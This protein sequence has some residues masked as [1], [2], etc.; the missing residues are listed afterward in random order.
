[1]S[2]TPS[3]CSRRLT[4]SLTAAVTSGPSALIEPLPWMSTRSPTSSGKPAL[5]TMMSW[6]LDSPLPIFDDSRFCWPTL[7][8]MTVHHEQDPA[9]DRR[10]AVAGAP[11]P[12]R[13]P[14]LGGCILGG[15][16]R[17]N[18]GG[19]GWGPPPHRPGALC[20]GGRGPPRGAARRLLLQIGPP[21]GARPP[22]GGGGP[23][24]GGAPARAAPRPPTRAPSPPR[25]GRGRAR[26]RGGPP[27]PPSPPPPPPPP[28]V[29]RSPPPPPPPPGCALRAGAKASSTPTWSC[30]APHWNQTLPRAALASGAGS[31]G[32]PRRPPK[33]RAPPPRSRAGPRA[34]RGR[35]R[36]S[37]RGLYG[38]AHESRQQLAVRV[39]AELEH[40][41]RVGGDPRAD[42]A[43]LRH[44]RGRQPAAEL[45]R[46]PPRRRRGCGSRARRGR[47]AGGPSR[48]RARPR[49]R[50]RRSGRGRPGAGEHEPRPRVRGAQDAAEPP[51]QR[52]QPRAAALQPGRALVALR[53][54]RLRIW[55][56][57]C[58]S[59][60][61]PPSGPS[62]NSRSAAS[63]RSRYRFGSRSPRHGD[64]QRPIWP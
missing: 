38:P 64:R 59:S 22:R 41:R 52:L 12:P 46:R 33:N 5:S 3:I 13:A 43:R 37:C 42:Q 57:M 8:P 51:Q 63:S 28:V 34:G 23:V 18:E 4:T 44:L 16:P 48:A 58:A 32:R 49:S 10:L 19:R 1:M 47:P 27:P 14:G 39:V 35:C 56:S 40:R 50:T 61:T 25:R 36:R 2:V 15:S 17:G 60:A 11:P 29:G 31:S 45:R 62:T 30:C 20:G 7:P 53:R 9:E 6:R 21:G 26:P 54:R 24:R 55:P